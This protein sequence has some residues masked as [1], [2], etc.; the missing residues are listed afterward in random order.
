MQFW[1]GFYADSRPHI[2][3][4]CIFGL[5]VDC[6]TLPSG[7]KESIEVLWCSIGGLLGY[8]G[9]YIFNPSKVNLG[10]SQSNL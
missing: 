2:L 3:P 6:T 4:H 8:I 1:R 7:D 5:I 9:L 10:S